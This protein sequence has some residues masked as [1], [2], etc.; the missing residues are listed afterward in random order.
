M[1]MTEADLAAA[2]AGIDER[3]RATA[4]GFDAIRDQNPERIWPT[5]ALALGFY[6]TCLAAGAT[7][8][9]YFNAR[10]GG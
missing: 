1:S 10:C 4:A 9:V 7:L 6:T 3:M 2:I 5:M 8:E